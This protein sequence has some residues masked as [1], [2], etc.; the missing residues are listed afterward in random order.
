[1]TEGIAGPLNRVA[2][3]WRPRIL[4]QLCR[5]PTSPFY[6]AAD[7]NWWHYKIRDFPSIIQQQAG[8]A[9]HLAGGLA[10][11][12]GDRAALDALAAASARFWT[13][14]SITH[15]AFEDYYPYEQGDPPLAFA[16]LA[17]AKLAADGVVPLAEIAPGLRVAARQLRARFE[18]Q[19]A[20]QQVAGLAALAWLDK[21][22]PGQADATAFAALKART[23]A[24]QTGE[25][26]FWEYDGPDLG[27]LAVTL[28]CL[29]D[30]FDATGDADYRRAID[31]ALGFMATIYAV[32]P[33]G[34]GML[35]A[36]NTDYLAPYGIVRATLEGSADAALV[37]HAA[38]GDAD[39]PEHAFAAVDD[40]YLCHYLGPSLMRACLL[41]E[42][43]SPLP[44][45]RGDGGA[46]GRDNPH[47]NP[48]P[49]GEGLSG[50]LLP[51]CGYYLAPGI[52]VAC[53]KGGIVSVGGEQEFGWIVERGGHQFVSHWWSR[54]WSVSREGDTLRVAGPLFAHTERAA[55]PA[56]HVVLRLL[57][58]ALGRRLIGLLKRV[59]I[60]KRGGDT[61]RL[62][63]EVQV[64]AGSVA[65]VDR[66]T[67]L[68]PSDRLVRAPRASKRHVAS[69]DSYHRDDLAA[70]AAV[71]EGR[72][73]LPDGRL[74]IR[75][76]LS[77]P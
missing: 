68:R 26:W 20:N 75:S 22:L 34:L 37:A 54:E 16:T 32:L 67:G 15:G 64:S 19:A 36:R 14:R 71:E 48:S 3:A 51:E 77:R 60:F 5:D 55:T 24:L 72:V 2:E 56:K 47:P 38:F 62:E 61:L 52:A 49:G 39:G 30:L 42:G 12:S 8:Y 76:R 17:M 35:N 65:I 33:G 57:S 4:T 59:L 44:F 58:F 11:W 50:R 29:W 63:R 66:F 73:T 40:R 43:A 28:D 7:R 74:E 45:G 23:L 9:M 70:S 53:R 10:R 46:E 18:A 25:G 31:R 6:G 1:V 27:Y 13:A 21:L 41:L 69:A